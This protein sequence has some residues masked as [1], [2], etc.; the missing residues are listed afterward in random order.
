MK[1]VLTLFVLA[2]LC[3]CASSLK[4]AGS[5]PVGLAYVS[6][7]GEWS[8]GGGITAVARVMESN[9]LAAVCGAWMTD[10][11]SALSANYNEDVMAA[12]AVFAGPTRMV[13]NLRF[14]RRVAYR[15]NLAGETANCVVS[16]IPWTAQLA[17]APVKLR[18]PRITFG[19]RSL[20]ASGGFGISSGDTVTF[21][22]TPR[23]DPIR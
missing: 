3:G 12:G 1:Q 18:F 17:S 15:D 2:V 13:N 21:R 5:D 9:G 4:P 14:M 19:D 20:S 10:P 22:Q 6:G 23:P 8:S 11:Q 16:S 7:G